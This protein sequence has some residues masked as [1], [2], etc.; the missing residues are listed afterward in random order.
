[1]ATTWTIA[2]D[3]D[4]NGNYTDTYDD[5]TSRVISTSWFLGIRQPYKH[6]A[7]SSTL[8]LI[9]DNSDKRYS[10]E[11]TSS[12]LTGKAKPF[13]QV[14]VQSNDGTTT[15]THWIGWIESLKPA[16]GQRGKRTIEIVA[17]G[18]LQF[19]TA[20]ETKLPLQENKRTDEII[21]ELIKKVVFPPALA[22]AWVLGRTGNSEV[23]TTT[24]LADTSAY[25]SLE[26]GKLIVGMAADNWVVNGG[27]ANKA[28]DTF[29]VYQ[30]IQDITAA[31]HGR[32]LFDR[33]G[34]AVFWNRHHL[35]LDNTPAA[36]FNDTMNDMVYSY[37]GLEMM[38]NEI[39]VICHPRTISPTADA[40]LWELGD[41]L[42]QVD[43]GKTREIYIKYEDEN[44]KRIGARD[45]TVTGIEYENSSGTVTATV[46]ADANGANLK[47]AN[48]G[49]K[50]AFIKKCQVQG[51]KIVD[52]GDMEAKATDSASLVDYG[53]RTLR[54]NLPSVD[55]LE[56]AQYIADFER[57]RR[58]QPLG[59]V[60]SLTVI[61][62]ATDGGSHHTQQL[63]RTMGDCIQI[64]EVQTGH[65]AKHFIIG[66]AHELG[67]AGAL[68][69]TTWY[70]EPAHPAPLAWKLGI[71]G[72]SN[73]NNSTYLTF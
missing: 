29:N 62:H 35:L 40:V 23:G 34:K 38:K 27:Y 15:R 17:T 25:S 45:V 18:P 2:V 5:V 36:T 59:A 4:R 10:P 24:F 7:D 33:E 14:R 72:R 63:A 65:S 47:F 70:L 73:L 3:W 66:E 42:I 12:P 71:S 37:A 68:W 50:S 39:T 53:K 30:A 26:A 49:T 11:Y 1:M 52:S 28:K 64:T 43:A 8:T 44:G 21:A 51:R 58:G 41:A 57:D 22:S 31:E 32:F 6:D 16:L 13:R 56:Q 67:M 69:K 61:S 46:E 48:G 19:Y 20:A 55:K 54:I 60:L 9:L